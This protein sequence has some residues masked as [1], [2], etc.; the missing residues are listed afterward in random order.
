M[1]E[2]YGILVWRN[3]AAAR[4]CDGATASDS[5]ERRFS[6]RVLRLPQSNA[7]LS[8]PLQAKRRRPFEVLKKPRANPG[9]IKSRSARF[10]V[11][12]NEN[13]AWEV[14]T[15]PTRRC[16]S[17]RHRLKAQMPPRFFALLAT[18]WL[19]IRS[20]PV[21]TALSAFHPVA[22]FADLSMNERR[23]SGDT[24]HSLPSLNPRR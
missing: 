17:K 3:V 10:M 14:C 21:P 15:G 8:R 6:D 18:P 7:W 12:M 5:L 4:S 24:R 1:R 2:R 22:R 19:P 13:D 16:E 23:S 11:M 20:Y 9:K